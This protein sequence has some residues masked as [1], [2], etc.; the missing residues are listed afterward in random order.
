MSL[1][2]GFKAQ[3]K[4][5]T[6]QIE[7]PMVSRDRSSN[8]KSNAYLFRDLEFELHHLRRRSS[9]RPRRSSGRLAS[10]FRSPRV[11]APSGLWFSGV[12]VP[13]FSFP[14]SL[15][16]RRTYSLLLFLLLLNIIYIYIVLFSYL[17]YLLYFWFSRKINY[18]ILVY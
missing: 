8:P 17:I 15:F 4:T 1:A 16:P 14:S 5:P 9:A 13:F 11:A 6:T 2:F 3:T 10:Q 7:N 12:T 18:F